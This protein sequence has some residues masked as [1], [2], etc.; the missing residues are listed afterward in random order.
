MLVD[1]KSLWYSVLVFRYGEEAGLMK[2]GGRGSSSWW[3]EI[4]RIR[5]GEGVEAVG[6][7]AEGVERRVGNGV[8]GRAVGEV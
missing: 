5:D 6:W 7:F 2:V 8:G 3:R 4:T 1:K